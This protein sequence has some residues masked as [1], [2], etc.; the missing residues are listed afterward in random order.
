MVPQDDMWQTFER[1]L[2]MDGKGKRPSHSF[3]HKYNATLHAMQCC[4]ACTLHAYLA[5]PTR[6]QPF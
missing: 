4:I 6:S 3:L 5:T 1:R 2:I